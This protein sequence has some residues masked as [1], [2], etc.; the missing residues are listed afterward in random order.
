M[1]TVHIDPLDDTAKRQ[2][3]KAVADRG[4]AAG[5]EAA[6]KILTEMVACHNRVVGTNTI[7]DLVTAMNEKAASIRQGAEATI[8][9]LEAQS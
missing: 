1:T 7:R 6:A 4:Q 9:A 2:L 5:L 3:L 8:K